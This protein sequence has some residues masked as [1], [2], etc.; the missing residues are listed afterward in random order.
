M[1]KVAPSLATLST[2][3]ATVLPMSCSLRSTNTFLP[4]RRAAGPAAG[5]R[6]SRAD[7]RSCRTSRCRRAARSSLPR[8]RRSGRSSATINRSL[9]AISAGCMSPHIMRWEK[10]I[11]CRTSALQRLDIGR[12]FQPVHIIIGLVGERQRKLVRD[13][14]GVAGRQDQPQ[15]RQRSRAAEPVF[16]SRGD[17]ERRA[18]ET[19]GRASRA[20]PAR[21]SPSRWCSSPAP[22]PTNYIPASRS[23]RHDA[24]R[25]CA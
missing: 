7:S 21:G 24:R 22:A 9:G 25:S 13:H 10:S 16:G 18:R 11:N 8:R 5:R 2:P 19:P 1:R 12:V 17:R 4:R 14:G 23:A 15:R 3:R 20:D 6:H